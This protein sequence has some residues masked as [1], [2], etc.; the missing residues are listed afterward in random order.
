M[1][2]YTLNDQ[3]VPVIASSGSTYLVCW[4]SDGQDTNSNGTYGQLLDYSGLKIG[5]EMLINE[6]VQDDQEYPSIASN[7]E[8]YLAVW[9]SNGQDGDNE[10]VFARII[11]NEGSFV[12][13]EFIVND[14]TTSDQFSPCVTSNGKSY[15]IAWSSSGQD[16]SG[17][18]VYASLFDNDGTEIKTEF[19]VNVYS[20]G[21]QIYPFISTDGE[22]Y[23]ISWTSY[24]LTGEDSD[25]YARMVDNEGT[26]ISPELIVN[27]KKSG[28]QKLL[29]VASMGL[30]YLIV[31]DSYGTQDN[32][33]MYGQI[34]DRQGAKIG[35]Q[36]QI[37]DYPLGGYYTPSICSMN[38][39]YFITFT[40]REED[41][42]GDMGVYAVIANTKYD[43]LNPDYDNDGLLD[44]EEVNIYNSN[45]A[46]TDSDGDGILDGVEVNLHNTSPALY[47]TDN[48]G[49]SDYEE[50]N[51]S[52]T[53]PINPDSDND[54]MY[55]GWEIDNNF[56]PFVNDGS[57]DRDNDGLANNQ[58]FLNGTN[59]DSS[60]TD[61]DGIPDK[62]E[63]DN[64]TKPVF[65]DSSDDPDNDGLDN[66]AEYA[67]LTNPNL[68]DTDVDGQNDSD[69]IFASTDPLDPDSVF[70]LIL[71]SDNFPADEISI[72]WSVEPDM[73]YIIYWSDSL[74]P[75]AVWDDVDYPGLESDI[76]YDPV[77]SSSNWTDNGDD[78][79]MN[80]LKPSQVDNRYYKIQVLPK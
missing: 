55:D 2:T 80:G 28:V 36:F 43:P 71:S 15:L 62:W 51:D 56:N 79:E 20:T 77:S 54:G 14:Y 9:E 46:S 25:V 42:D 38:G 19:K 66:T 74:A 40:F 45:P 34:F 30:N 29:A 72:T 75:F 12:T 69:E 4:N 47:D 1:N 63:V 33:G 37:T 17:T 78:P 44:G 53:D 73:D 22:N 59:P 8:N 11:D 23:L 21:S 35:P 52:L 48:D 3:I 50:I 32:Y 49:L 76:I 41:N 24:S 26:F 60:D 65:D 67:N 58:E 61:N 13:S 57:L 64:N 7:G 70:E 31:W 16:G 27:T 18:G 68:A 39:D 6:F 5:S 10:G